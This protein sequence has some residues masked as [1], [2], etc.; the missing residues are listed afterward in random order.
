MCQSGRNGRQFAQQR[1]GWLLADDEIGI[2]GMQRLLVGR[3]G[4][5]GGQ[6]GV[7]KRVEKVE[8]QVGEGQGGVVASHHLRGD[9]QW[10]GLVEHGVGGGDG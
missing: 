7:D 5:A 9:G 8:F 6:A 3:Q 10:I 1:P 4:N 2:V